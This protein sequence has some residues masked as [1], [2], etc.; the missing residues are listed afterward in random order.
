MMDNDKNNL[1]YLSRDTVVSGGWIVSVCNGN[2]QQPGETYTKYKTA[3]AEALRR[4]SNELLIIP[5]KDIVADFGKDE[6]DN[7]V[8]W[9]GSDYEEDYQEGYEGWLLC[10]N[11]P[12]KAN[13]VDFVVIENDDGEL[14]LKPT[15]KL[16]AIKKYQYFNIE[17]L[18]DNVQILDSEHDHDSN[19][20]HDYI[21]DKDSQYDSSLP[22]H[23]YVGDSNYRPLLNIVAKDLYRKNPFRILGLPI[24]ASLKEINRKQKSIEMSIDLETDLSQSISGIL[25][26]EPSPDKHQIKSAVEQ[27]RDPHV[28]LIYGLFWFWQMNHS[29]DDGIVLLHKRKLNEALKCWHQSEGDS[30]T[31][32]IAVHNIALLYHLTALDIEERIIKGAA[33]EK[34][35][36]T[37][38][39]HWKSAYTRWH[40]LIESDSFGN[41]LIQCLKDIDDVRLTFDVVDNIRCTLPKALLN[42]NAELAVNASSRGDSKEVERHLYLM[43]SSGFDNKIIHEVL[44][45]STRPVIERINSLCSP[46]TEKAKMTPGDANKIVRDLLSEIKSL[47]RTLDL[48][49]PDDSSFKEKCH[50]DVAATLRGCIVTYGNETADWKECLDLSREAANIAMGKSIKDRI[51]DD[52]VFLDRNLRIEEE[53]HKAEQ[54][55]ELS[56]N[57]NAVYEVVVTGNKIAVPPLCTCCLK[58]ADSQQS[59]SYS[60]TEQRTL[61]KVERTVSFNFPVCRECEKHQ[62]Q[63]TTK[64]FLLI[65]LSALL[66]VGI[67]YMI[68]SGSSRFEYIEYVIPGAIISL[69]TLAVLSFLLRV[70]KITDEHA[71]RNEAVAMENANSDLNYATFRFSN[72]LYALAFAKANNREIN[73][74]TWL[75]YSRNR[76]LLRGRSAFQVFIWVAILSLIG[77]SI[78]YS[79]LDDNWTSK[80]SY[81]TSTYS[82]PSSSYTRQNYNYSQGSSTLISQINSGKQNLRTMETELEQIDSTIESLSTR[83]NLLKSQVD[84][85]ESAAQKGQYVNQYSYNSAIENHNN[86]VNEYNTVL[87]KRKNKYSEYE[88]EFK[89]I[90]GLIDRY[91]RR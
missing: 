86:L 9:L 50:D 68:G 43:N 26:L 83:I 51:N 22:D 55:H 53:Q 15:Q 57:T 63:L 35:I 90:N 5:K 31:G 59:V 77:H 65:I 38:K 56:L 76:S 45:N 19:H 67:L 8:F 44:R 39:S 42:I 80:S 23:K 13:A 48:L 72:Y 11:V 82:R 29:K 74:K 3:Q 32:S 69:I 89:R 70:Q 33:T 81:G 62:G 71:A 54:E 52:I 47:I 75:K 24:N 84:G 7:A 18:P 1:W 17:E 79:V 6:N 46:V 21:E 64:R 91:N 78:A 49:T 58:E 88:Q 12:F 87:A 85:Y 10:D 66:P 2:M 14:I 30:N 61:S 20:N 41:S 73:K 25:P 27:I 36:E 28:R 4:N 37:C 40:G 34:E 60:W 16:L